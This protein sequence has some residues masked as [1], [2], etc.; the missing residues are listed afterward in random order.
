[1]VFQLHLQMKVIMKQTLI[2][3]LQRDLSDVLAKYDVALAVVGVVVTEN[4]ELISW[5]QTFIPVAPKNQE[6]NA[7]RDKASK[8]ISDIAA[9]LTET[10]YN[11][12]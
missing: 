6:E 1:M 4:G 5:G 12:R 2:K 9:K 7:L 10:V 11:G 3:R 8:D